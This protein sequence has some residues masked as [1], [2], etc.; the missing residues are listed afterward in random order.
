MPGPRLPVV[1]EEITERL[2]QDDWYRVS[3]EDRARKYY[4]VGCADQT[5]DLDGEGDFFRLEFPTPTKPGPLSQWAVRSQLA[6]NKA[7]NFLI[8]A[9]QNL[10]RAGVPPGPLIASSPVK[11]MT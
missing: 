3:T 6:D 9:R 7:A 2:L 4:I 8:G 10:E 5:A 1:L 11:W